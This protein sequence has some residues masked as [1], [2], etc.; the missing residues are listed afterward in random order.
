[1]QRSHLFAGTAIALV[2][3]AV[4][5]IAQQRGEEKSGA[6]QQTQ[7]AESKEQGK[8]QQG[9]KAGREQG[10]AQN[11]SKEKSESKERGAQTKEKGSKGTAQAPAREQEKKGSAQTEQKGSKGTA[12][13][14]VKEQEK[15]GSAQT[16]PQEKGGKGTAQS[17]GK[18]RGTAQ[19]P[20]KEQDKMGSGQAQSK[21]RSSKENAQKQP[22]GGEAQKSAGRPSPGERT[23]LS[24]Q[25][26]SNLHQTILKERNVNRATNVNVSVSVG[27]RIPHSVRLAPIPASVIS[28]VPA[29]R[30]YKYVVIN[31]QICVVD[32]NSFEIVEV[33]AAPGQTARV[34]SHG[35]QAR[36]V[37]TEEEKEIVLRSVEMDHGST[38]GLGTLTEGSTVPRGAKLE[39]FPN[40]VVQEVPKL[41]GHKYVAAENRVAI[42]DPQSDKVQLVLE[43]KH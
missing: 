9:T 42:V 41:K 13:A 27:T 24:E 38:L 39:A 28:I 30:S 4:P 33:I 36:L 20:G 8:S 16:E 21:D 35:G 34:D 40:T 14:P 18:D 2:M 37:L 19:A 5:A 17:P 23:Q 12:Q 25:Q 3:C 10:A 43:G 11:E 29:Y 7:G 1:M 22:T 6:A 15:K 32:P 31:D 26:R